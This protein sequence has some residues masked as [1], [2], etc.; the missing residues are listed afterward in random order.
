[1]RAIDRWEAFQYC[2]VFRNRLSEVACERLIA[3]HQE[4]G[5]LRSTMVEQQRVH[6]GQ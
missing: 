6:Q 4:T 5:A 3:L 2:E 1:M